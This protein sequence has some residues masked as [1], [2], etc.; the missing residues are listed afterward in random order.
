MS[1]AAVDA[2]LALA[3]RRTLT[4]DQVLLRQND[5]ADAFF[6]VEQGYLKLTQ[7]T[8][9][10][11]EVIVRFVGPWDPVGAVAAVDDRSY[12]VTATACDAVHVLTWPRARLLEAL[13]KY[14]QLKSNILREI[15]AHMDNALTRL[16]ELAT[17]N[18]TQRL[19][20]TLL[21]LTAGEG[22]VAPQGG[23][24]V[25]H[26]LTR[27]ELAELTGTTLFT[28]SRVLTSWEAS[29]LVRSSR[30]HVEVLDPEGL[31]RAADSAGD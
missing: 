11:A 16:R 24:V 19:A 9:D 8:Q 1:D 4:K 27:Q 28:A 30:A 2:V 23:R 31:Q 26:A 7:I 22:A 29:G 14:P 5:R 17:L 12:P 3:V 18:V 13:E 10:G 21:R 20:H 25:P 6:L 15:S